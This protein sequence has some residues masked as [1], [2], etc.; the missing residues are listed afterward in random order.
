M[1]LRCSHSKY[2]PGRLSVLTMSNK[3]VAIL[4]FLIQRVAPS[5]LLSACYHDF[6]GL[7]A[8][9]FEKMLAVTLIFQ[10]SFD[11]RHHLKYYIFI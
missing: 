1:S 10:P 11:N 5:R 8:T 4:K 2:L 7:F 9:C 6:H 3:S